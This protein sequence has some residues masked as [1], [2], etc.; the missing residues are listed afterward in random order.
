M[1]ITKVEAATASLSLVGESQFKLEC[2][3]RSSNVEDI[4][5]SI[6]YNGG[7]RVKGFLTAEE[8]AEAEKAVRPYLDKAGYSHPEDQ[9]KR[10]GR[11]PE[12]APKMTRKILEDEL[13]LTIMDRFLSTSF[14]SWLEDKHVSITEKPIVA[15]SS[16]FEV[17]PGMHVQDLHRD[18]SIWFNAMDAIKP[19]DYQYGRDVSISFFIAGSKTTEANGAT[20]FIPGSHLTKHDSPPETQ[21]AI[22]AELDAGDAFFMLSSCYHGAGTNSTVNEKRLVY[23]L[24]MQKAHLRQVRVGELVEMPWLTDITG[25]ELCSLHGPRPRPILPHRVPAPSW[26]RRS[27]PQPRMGGSRFAARERF[28]AEGCRQETDCWLQPS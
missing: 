2:F 23:A 9:T 26:F 10:L 25:G 15:M 1:T 16:T 3:D 6:K 8:V 7:V 14:E 11:L 28:E 17:G 19:E 22:T 20:R 21:R 5:N 24:F 13:Y 27:S 18:D 4:I 12:Q